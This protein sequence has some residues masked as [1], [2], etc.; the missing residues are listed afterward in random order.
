[1]PNFRNFQRD[2]Q[3][4]FGTNL[5]GDEVIYNVLS[6]IVPGIDT[7]NIEVNKN[8]VQG[9]IQGSQITFQELTVSI[10]VDED[11]EAWKTVVANLFKHVE[12]PSGKMT[13]NPADSWVSI[14]SSEG[15]DV[16]KLQ[17]INCT[18]MNLTPLTYDNSSD[19]NVL[20]FDLNIQFDYFKI[21]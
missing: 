7:T 2:T 19:N 15:I 18:L 17:F 6:V 10:L 20:T 12:L 11:M 14:K 13:M 1:M 9:W 4:E 8:S 21:V 16:L 3:I 5:F